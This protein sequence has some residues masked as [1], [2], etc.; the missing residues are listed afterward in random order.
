MVPGE[1]RLSLPGRH[2]HQL[3]GQR[4]QYISEAGEEVVRQQASP[5]AGMLQA[6]A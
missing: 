5:I 2:N 6:H 3:F 4:G 1:P